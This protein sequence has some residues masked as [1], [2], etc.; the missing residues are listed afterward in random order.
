MLYLVLLHKP[1]EIF[2]IQLSLSLSPVFVF[3]RLFT[4]LLF[5]LVFKLQPVPLVYCPEVS[6]SLSSPPG[7]LETSV[8]CFLEGQT[9]PFLSGGLAAFPFSL[10][11]N[12]L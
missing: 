9:H 8:I 12:A 5:F 11:V 6:F 10:S 4:F 1:V 7:P 2:S 3:T